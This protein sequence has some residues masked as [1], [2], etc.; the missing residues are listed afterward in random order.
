MIRVDR[1]RPEDL[2]A[3]AVQPGQPE[4]LAADRLALGRAYAAQG[5][6]LTAR[7]AD[8]RLLV[9]GGAIETHGDYATIWSAVS[10]AAGPAM[11]ALTRATTR[12]LDTLPYR[13]VDTIVAADF[14]PGRRWVRR[15]GFA[16]EAVLAEYFP[17][18]RDAVIYRRKRD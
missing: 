6:C 7:A 8:G 17:D 10:V 11:L 4:L 13:R 9:C 12:F 18:G 16:Q 15:M 5:R 1:F 14:I 3:I 2:A